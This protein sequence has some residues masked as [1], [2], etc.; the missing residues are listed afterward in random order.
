M[1]ATK[2]YFSLSEI[3]DPA[4]HRDHNEWH[5]LDHRPENL[6]LPGI[7]WGDRWVRSPDCAAASR[8][9]D[10]AC[11]NAHY[12]IMYWFREPMRETL[13]EWFLLTE[14]S[15]QWGR[16]PQVGWTRRPVRGSF[17]PIKGYASPRTRLSPEEIVFR[18]VQGI[19]VML[20]RVLRRD[21][22]AHEAWRWQDEVQIPAL[23]DCDG[24]AGAW[25]FASE[26]QFKPMHADPQ[27]GW[28]FADRHTRP[29]EQPPMRLTLLYLDGDPV[30]VA[31]RIAGKDADWRNSGQARD[32]SGIEEVFFASP[33]R[34]VV[35]WE[36]SWFD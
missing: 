5:Q 33:L 1:F 23:L 15:F 32:L 14:R 13:D 12:A 8:V 21:A 6:L 30:E 27:P 3:T 34:R 20:S 2:V 7:G 11:A 10:A 17:R 35:P 31:K 18:P 26:D 16:S 9:S 28:T 4:K 36:W 25:T 24:V 22:A 19:Y 29:G